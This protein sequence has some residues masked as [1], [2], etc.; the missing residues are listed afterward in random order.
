[1]S[2]TIKEL[3]ELAGVSRGTVDRAIHN[4][5]GVSEKAKQRIL[6][7]AEAIGYQPNIIAKSLAKR[8]QQTKIGVLLCSEG[9]DYYDEVIRGMQQA[10]SEIKDFGFSIISEHMNGYD[11]SDQIKLLHKLEKENISGLVLTPINDAII[12]NK[13]HAFTKSN[14]PIITLNTTMEEDDQTIF[15]GVDYYKSGQTAG[16][17]MGL[18]ATGPT[19]VLIV[20]ASKKIIAHNRRAQGFVD[21][22]SSDFPNIEIMDI[23]E[24][25]DS[26]ELSYNKVKD[27]IV[28]HPDI[29]GVYFANAGTNGGIKAIM[30]AG[31]EH[32]LKII[33]NDATPSRIQRLKDGIINAP[34]C[35]QPF[36]QGYLSIKTLFD[37]I[38]LNKTLKK[39]QI[40][41]D[42]EIK[43][44]YNI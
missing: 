11:I 10:A 37:S 35:Q 5:G 29:L 12:T 40:Y 6:R 42:I 13:L 38:I 32:K 15:V 30:D 1:M 19:K 14:I 27:Y 28:K 25:N 18:M 7:I 36:E 9:N 8:G 44:K 22:V 26:N 4:R 39:E 21:A 23:I 33:T 3:A 43:L 34:V 20:L 31:L 2:A 24:N 17:L 41:T 16:G